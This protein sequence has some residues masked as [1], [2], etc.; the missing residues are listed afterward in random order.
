[1]LQPE[2]SVSLKSPV[3]STYESRQQRNLIIDQ[4]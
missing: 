2:D 3:L 4:P 1:M